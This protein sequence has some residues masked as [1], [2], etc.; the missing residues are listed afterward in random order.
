MKRLLIGVSS[1][2]FLIGS[3][4]GLADESSAL[5]TAK[6]KFSY[7]LGA[8]TAKNFQI[9]G[10]DVNAAVFSQGFQDGLSN[11][12]SNKT[13][14]MSDKEIRTAIINFQNE[15]TKNK[16]TKMSKAYEENKSKGDAFLKENKG[17]SGVTTL[18]DGLQYKVDKM[19]HGSKPA[20]DDMVT[21]HYTGKL[22]DGTVFDSSVDRGQPATFPVSGVIKGWTEAL[23]LMPVGSKWTLYIP[24]SLAYGKQGAGD[25]IPPGSTLIFDVELLKMKSSDD[26]NAQSG[27][28]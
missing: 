20:K 21:V 19:G 22:I 3:T 15:L 26:L 1:L 23:Q 7:A 8:E 10:M 6:D 5:S 27:R 2:F 18:A 9:H 13:L 28:P 4:N 11:T 16:L 14:K 24:E 25:S 12:A 17:K